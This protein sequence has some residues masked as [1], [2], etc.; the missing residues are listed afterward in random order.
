MWAAQLCPPSY[1]LILFVSIS[2]AR[3]ASSLIFV[4][5][6]GLPLPTLS[7]H[8]FAVCMSASEQA[9]SD[10]RCE[11]PVEDVSSFGRCRSP[12]T[13]KYQ[14]VCQGVFVFCCS[15]MFMPRGN[16]LACK[17]SLFPSDGSCAAPPRG[18]CRS[19]VRAPSFCPWMQ[20]RKTAVCIR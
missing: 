1:L 13:V 9:V 17:T 3:R 6:E 16:Q 20:L 7:S 8:L 12:Q 18:G 14:T 19:K 10:H 11:L 5:P 15:V 2:N 4:A